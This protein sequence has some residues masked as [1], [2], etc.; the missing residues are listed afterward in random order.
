MKHNFYK[1]LILIPLF[2]FIGSMSTNLLFAHSKLTNPSTQR[3]LLAKAELAYLGFKYSIAAD[4][5][6]DYL[7]LG[8]DSSGTLLAKLADCYW[9]TKQYDDAFRVYKLMLLHTTQD[10]SSQ[11]RLRIAE[12]YARFRDYKQA[13]KWLTGIDGYQS[14]AEV[15]GDTLKMKALTKDSLNWRIEFLNINTGFREFS[16]FITDDGNF[17]FFSSDRPVFYSN[18]H[19]N[20]IINNYDRLWKVPASSTHDVPTLKGKFNMIETDADKLVSLVEGLE[21]LRFNVGA[22]AADKNNHFYFS[23]NYPNSDRRGINRLRLMEGFYT[24]KNSLKKKAL[25]FGNP[26]LFSVTHPTVNRDGTFLVLSSD[27]PNGKGNYDLYYT[28]RKSISQPWDTLKAFGS[29]INT[30][31]NEVFPSLISN[32]YLYFSSDGLPGLG[33]LDIYR[34]S[35]QDAINGKDNVDHLSYPINSSGDDLGWTQDSTTTYGYFSSDRLNNDDDIYCFHYVN[36]QKMRLVFG[37]TIDIKTNKPIPNATVF[38]W[39][40]QTNKVNIA[41]TDK[42]G[43]YHFLV[44]INDPIILKAVKKG[45][46]NDCLEDEYVEQS[47]IADTISS[48]I[49][50]LLLERKDQDNISQIDLSDGI[51]AVDTISKVMQNLLFKK[52]ILKINDNWRLNNIYYS[53]NKWDIRADAKPILDSLIKLLKM[54]PIRV[55]LG[56]HTDSR[57]TFEY[58]DWLSQKRAES[59]VDY[60]VSH[61]VNS[62]RLTA[63]GYGERVLLNRC[64][65]GIPCSEKEHQ[66]NRRTE[67]RVIS[68]TDIQKYQ[69]D[70]IDPDQFSDEEQI[71]KDVLPDDFFSYCDQPSSSNKQ[72]PSLNNTSKS[73]ENSKQ[74]FLIKFSPGEF[75][76]EPQYQYILNEL[77]RISANNPSLIIQITAQDDPNDHSGIIS[78]MRANQIRRFLLDRG[79]SNTRCYIDESKKSKSEIPHGT[80]MLYGKNVDLDDLIMFS[81]IQSYKG[82]TK[83]MIIRND[84]EQYCV[85]F[86]AFK[87]RTKSQRLAEKIQS[88]LSIPIYV[89][90]ENDYFKIRTPY[91]TNRSTAIEIAA[92]IQATGVLTERLEL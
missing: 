68:N 77:V 9:I 46:T 87:T 40:K 1:Y 74:R 3:K 38:M 65:D 79:I 7:K 20:K 33:G 6:E 42:D 14:R 45:M 71:D 31:G 59:V 34:I 88:I 85:Q 5:Y 13:S 12:L 16:P 89:I 2:I 47:Q 39:N 92:I 30:A 4:Y 19:P 41:K 21:K 22:V 73:N 18:E 43:K 49:R 70:D 78:D 48:N 64:T 44:P 27:R 72:I 90:E 32:G 58:N 57:G 52:Q 86:G 26:R 35:L 23:T 11:Q 55:E 50:D 84:N 28:Q 60:L 15:F 54:Y 81:L 10:I 83:E 29:N 24:R 36:R 67:V 8:S 62:E 91:S 76:I 75:V 69:I 53:F 61:G 56:S 17:L 25:P 51:Q 63:R 80:A 37:H 82:D 66:D